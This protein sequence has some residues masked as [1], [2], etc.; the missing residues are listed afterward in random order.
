[1][2]GS[3]ADWP[4]WRGNGDGVAV[5]TFAT[6]WSAEENVRWKAEL[7][8]PGNSS[9]IVAGKRV[10]ITQYDPETKARKLLCYSTENGDLLWEVAQ[11]TEEAE[12]TH[13]TNPYCAASPATNGEVV[14]AF[15]GSAGLCCYDL[16]GNLKWKK[17][18]GSPQHLFGQGASPLIHDDAGH[19]ELRARH[20]TVLDHA[21]ARRRQGAMATR[22]RQGRRAQSI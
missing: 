4:S 13:P 2:T 14:V 5:G 22:H 8:G 6:E 9:P 20:G 7:P 3:A 1:M 16:D 21:R 19:H 15:F 17:E 10:F 12:P 11:E 18:L